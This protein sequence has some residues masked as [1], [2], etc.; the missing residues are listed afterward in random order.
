MN[1]K[2][3]SRKVV[4]GLLLILVGVGIEMLGPRGLTEVTAAFLV[5]IGASYFA[6]NVGDKIAAS[7]GSGAE[8]SVAP[9]QEGVDALNQKLDA[10]AVNSQAER[11]G[12]MTAL[13]G[14]LSKQD[15]VQKKV[16]FI[17][18]KAGL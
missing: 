1:I 18:K 11:E 13:S 16:D 6:G 3:N 12:Y 17:I 8:P 2:W 9:V 4:F 5:A 10:I 14:I 7:K 15:E